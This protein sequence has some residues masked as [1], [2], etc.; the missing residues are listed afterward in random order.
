[1]IQ[2]GVTT[3]T[4][5][6]ILF[7]AG[8][9]FDGVTYNEKVAPT[10]EEVRPNICGATQEGGTI[11][12]TPKFFMPE[13]DDVYVDLE[14]LQNKVGE[15]AQM[16]VSFAELAAKHVAHAVIGTVGET[17]DKKYDVITS[18]SKIGAGHFYK[19]FGYYGHLMDG[20]PFIVIFKSALC[21][22]GFTADPK[23]GTNALFKGTF[24]CQSDIAYSTKKL[25]YAM[26]IHKEEGWVPVDPDEVAVA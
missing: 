5:S 9:Y 19:G 4:P 23:S 8:V 22:S 7:G 21:T 20:R 14:E 25:P 3:A 6:K 15:D 10:E 17:T 11:T 18:S 13:L 2:S 12:I 26:F 16:E 1:M 24:K